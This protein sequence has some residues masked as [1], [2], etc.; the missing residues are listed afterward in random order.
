[1]NKTLSALGLTAAMALSLT[2]CSGSAAQ[3]SASA[4]ADTSAPA[5][6]SSAV[7]GGVGEDGVFT[8][9]MECAYAP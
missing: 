6:T 2:A 3:P 5:E 1:M 9:G 4:P 7:S 8:V